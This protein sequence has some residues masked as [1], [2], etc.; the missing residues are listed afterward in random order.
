[1]LTYGSAL[2]DYEWVYGSTVVL[3]TGL[4]VDGLAGREGAG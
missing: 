3:L 1:M 4:V 2:V